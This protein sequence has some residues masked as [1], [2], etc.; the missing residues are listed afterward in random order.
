MWTLFGLAMLLSAGAQESAVFAPPKP[1]F[2]ILQNPIATVAS[3]ADGDGDVDLLTVTQMGALA[4]LEQS[5]P[6]AFEVHEAITDTLAA[7]SDVVLLDAST[8]SASWVVA[9]QGGGRLLRLQRGA[10]GEWTLDVLTDEAG[11]VLELR[12]A[13]VDQDG[14]DEIVWLGSGPDLGVLN[15]DGGQWTL[16]QT[17]SLGSFPSAL[18]V[19]DVDGDGFLDI[20]TG[21]LFNGNVR[22]RAGDGNGGFAQDAAV[23]ADFGGVREV[24]CADLDGNGSAEVVI[25]SNN[26]EVHI[27]TWNALEE[28]LVPVDTLQEG[29]STPYALDLADLDGDG[30]LDIVVASNNNG[31]VDLH[32]Q[33]ENGWVRVPVTEGV[34]QVRDV[35][36]ID[37]DGDGGLDVLSTTYNRDEVRWS[38][39]VTESAAPGWTWQDRSPCDGLYHPERLDVAD[40]NGDGKP[41]VVFTEQGKERLVV[42]TQSVEDEGGSMFSAPRSVDVP[43]GYFVT[44]IRAFDWDLDGAIEVGVCDYNGD[45]IQWFEQDGL[46]HFAPDTVLVEVDKPSSLDFADFNGDGWPDALW[47]SWSGSTIAVQWQTPMGFSEPL[48]LTGGGSRSE[49]AL[50]VDLNGDGAQ[51]VLAVF[52]NSS[53]AFVWYGD[54][55]GGFGEA[56]LVGTPSAPQDVAVSDADGDGFQDLY[57]ACFGGNSVQMSPGVFTPDSALSFGPTTEVAPFLSDG[58]T[59]LDA[60]D[61]D[62]D[63]RADVA[64]GPYNGARLEVHFSASDS[65]VAVEA[66]DIR[67]LVWADMDGDG[68]L[69]VIYTS[70]LDGA[71]EWLELLELPQPLSNADCPQDLDANSAVGLSDLIEFLT[72]FGC[73]EDCG[74]ADWTGDGAVGAA[75]LVLLLGAYGTTCPSP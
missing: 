20:L 40:V 60:V 70:Y 45:K 63:G 62:G 61:V 19:A 53:N 47:S 75:D 56:E 34:N 35:L 21:Q 6:G 28:T 71:V 5:Q 48:F 42:V 26:Q 8:G 38:R 22:W 44:G 13:D 16:G 33:T 54:G 27:M 12:A 67:D 17:W 57:F 73:E 23:V 66:S 10:D 58:A 3:D 15:R 39:Q 31:Q 24:R 18:E 7:C 64:V 49:R 4:W 29:V 59:H 55:A 41:D 72:V 25:G 1:V 32:L 46:G 11:S 37:V 2:P 43:G 14:E 68:D 50:A 9:E 51:D 30:G 36:A 52:E 69:D 74:P 65:T